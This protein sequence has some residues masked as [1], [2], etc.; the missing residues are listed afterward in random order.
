[1]ICLVVHYIQIGL[2]V[3]FFHSMIRNRNEYQDGEVG[4][5]VLYS[6][7]LGW[8]EILWWVYECRLLFVVFKMLIRAEIP[9]YAWNFARIK[10]YITFCFKNLLTKQD[11]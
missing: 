3:G 10:Y 2:V 5:L 4:I 1:M 6:I 7:F 8:T 9:G 11:I